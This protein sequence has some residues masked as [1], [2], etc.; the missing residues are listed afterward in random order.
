MNVV[1]EVVDPGAAGVLVHPHGPEGGHLF[2]GIPVKRGH[3]FNVFGGYPGDFFHLFRSIVFKKCFKCGKING[4]RFVLKLEVVLGAVSDV[5]F[6]L[7]KRDMFFYKIP[8]HPPVADDLVTDGIGHCQIGLWAKEDRPVRSHAAARRA[9]GKIDDF[10]MGSAFPR[11]KH[12]GEKDRVHFR[13]VVAPRHKDIGLFDI[14]I[15]PHG[16]VQPKTG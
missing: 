10:Y 11:G 7:V 8:V 2:V 6:S 13:H 9:G 16:F 1:D 14:L 12:P 15:A 4:F 3:I 5:G